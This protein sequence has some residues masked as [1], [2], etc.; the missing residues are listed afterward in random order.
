MD[1]R[2]SVLGGSVLVRKSHNGGTTVV[3]SIPAPP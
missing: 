2:A 3:C 1:H